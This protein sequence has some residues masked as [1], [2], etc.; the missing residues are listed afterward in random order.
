[1]V[2]DM[3]VRMDI[4][5]RMEDAEDRLED[6]IRNA[7]EG[8]QGEVFEDGRLDEDDLRRIN[9]VDEALKERGD[10]GLW[11]S[12]QYRIYTEETEDGDEIVSI[13][14]FG[15]PSIPSDIEAVDMDE[16]EREMYNDV[17]SDYG[18][19]VSERVEEQFEDWRAE[20]REQA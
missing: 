15:V 8:A 3:S 7:V 12:V 11:G 18:V 10:G 9:E 6:W 17:L 16:E 2:R 4:H 19:E 20:R 1:M 13:D 14:T 5:R